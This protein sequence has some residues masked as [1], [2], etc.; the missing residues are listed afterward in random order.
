MSTLPEE[1]SA[2]TKS[3]MA[4]LL[5]AFAP[6]K[7]TTPEQPP[8]TRNGP[9]RPANG[10]DRPALF[11]DSKGKIVA[12]HPRCADLFGRKPEE[13]S[14]FNI[15]DLLKP[16]FDRQITSILAQGKE[17][18]ELSFHVLALRKDGS[19]FATQFSL[20][21]LQDFNFRW[22]VF[23]QG[24][25][26][27]NGEAEQSAIEPQAIVPTTETI[28]TETPEHA[29]GEKPPPGPVV[30]SRPPN[31]EQLAA[32]QNERERLERIKFEADLIQLE[33]DLSAR[34]GAQ[35]QSATSQIKGTQKIKEQQPEPAA[36][37]EETQDEHAQHLETENRNLTDAKAKAK[38]ELDKERQAIKVSRKKEEVL[39][40]Q[41]QTLQGALE[42]AEARA[43]ESAPQSKDWEKRAAGLK[44][45]VDE[46]TRRHAA[47]QNAAVKAAQRV[48]ELEEQLKRAGDDQA[49]GKNDIEDQDATRQRLEAENRYLTEAIAKARADLN[50]ER[51][52]IKVSRKKEEELQAQVQTLQGTL[53]QAEDRAHESAPQ[54]RDWEKKVADLKK[55]VDELTRK[56]AA[57]QKAAVKAAQRIRELEEQVKCAGDDHADGIEDQDAAV[58]VSREREEELQTQVQTLQGVLEQ[59]EARASESTAQSKDWEK[60]TADLKKSVDELTRRHAAEQNAAAKRVKDL[61]QQLKRAGDDLAASKAENGNSTELAET[62]AAL[63]KKTAELEERIR[64]GVFSLAKVNAELE[65]ARAEREQAGKDASAAIAQTEKL[66]EKLKQQVELERASQSKIAELEKTIQDRGDDLAR[67]SAALRK[68]AKERQI[69]QKQSRLVSE[70]GG[71]LESNLASL[72][73][74]KKAFEESLNE[75]DERL[76]KQD[77]R[78][79]SVERSLAEANSGLEK[80]SAERRRLEGLLATARQQ[81]EKLSVESKAK[82]FKL[83]AALDLGELQRKQLEVDLLRSRDVAE[84]GEQEPGAAPENRA[85]SIKKKKSS[86]KSDPASK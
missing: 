50:K 67:A 75:K 64:K 24:P 41:V 19:E 52:A 28:T 59:A 12:A 40:N 10:S 62:Q 83:Q 43:H 70:I 81:L 39:Q 66:K 65:S 74:A 47:E 29:S 72:E 55:S 56:R 85:D 58:K 6:K 80:E 44:K 2:K 9:A 14:G 71:R 30:R 34:P 45:S 38:A 18:H 42:Q 49:A 32:S 7:K 51:E 13:L 54:P 36:T 15:K 31:S 61:E 33:E 68:E 84:N 26:G 77:E 5:T 25:A 11:L 63:E 69:A 27:S 17:A 20:K 78:L 23:V 86:P 53:E 79:Q 1:P 73:D 16:G 4:S 46:L 60:K 35:E 22:A 21:F 76:Q 82:I 37:P 57:E 48:R 8:A 3:R